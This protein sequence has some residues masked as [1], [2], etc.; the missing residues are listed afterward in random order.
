MHP[1]LEFKDFLEAAPD[2]M[3][4]VGSN[5]EIVLVNT[6]AEKLFGYTRQELLHQKLEI[7]IPARFHSAHLRHRT[8]YSAEPVVRPMGS[9]LELFG[10]RKNG[11]EF[12][13]EVSLSPVK[14]QRGSFTLSAIRDISERKL[15]EDRVRA[16]LH[17]KEIL[18]KEVH[19]RV[20][21]NLQV[22]SSILNLQNER[23]TD[24]RVKAI[25]NDTRSRVKSIALVHERLYQ[26][27]D[28][29]NID[30]DEY[31]KVLVSDLFQSYGVDPER[32]KLTIEAEPASFDVD[33]MVNCGLIV[34]ELV[35]NS[36]KYAFPEN[37]TGEIKIQLKVSQDNIVH[38]LVADNGIG[39]NI[40]A[41]SEK[42]KSLG[43]VLV[44]GLAR[45][46]GGRFE[47][48]NDK[49]MKAHITFP[50]IQQQGKAK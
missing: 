7:L 33:R 6:Q 18:L 4:V 49:G 2:A 11:K 21:N 19:H 38:L 43:L 14:T 22:I 40:E 37:R 47:T 12:P 8:K 31:V 35:S 34:S 36:L 10:L 41:L 5:G 23:V 42:S 45:E 25:L 44:R 28:L 50:L 20:K 9:A 27:S 32:I 39:A 13:L 17:E 1:E 3:V 15:I 26:S 16:S 30:F 24:E 46:L 29:V 48:E